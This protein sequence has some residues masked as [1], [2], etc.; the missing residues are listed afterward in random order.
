MKLN[1]TLQNHQ[2]KSMQCLRSLSTMK[3]MANQEIIKSTRYMLS[4]PFHHNHHHHQQTIRWVWPMPHTLCVLRSSTM[5]FTLPPIVSVKRSRHW[6]S[7]WNRKG[8][9]MMRH[10]WPS[11]PHPG[12]ICRNWMIVLP[13]YS[14]MPA[15]HR[16]EIMHDFRSSNKTHN[17]CTHW[18]NGFSSRLTPTVLTLASYKSDFTTPHSAQS[19]TNL[20][21]KSSLHD[22]R[23]ADYELSKIDYDEV[24][25]IC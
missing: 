12:P 9:R 13:R 17:E 24:D 6:S 19:S 16:S 15:G 5:A 3:A 7:R 8:T 22:E 14:V 2:S 4:K 25:E 23:L 21:R 11:W 10:W 20:S 1:S 18:H